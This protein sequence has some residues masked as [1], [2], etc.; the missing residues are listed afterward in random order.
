MKTLLKIIIVGVI[1]FS[2]IFAQGQSDVIEINNTSIQTPE[3]HDFGDVTEIEYVRYFIRNNRGSAVVVS[4]IKTPSGFFA[5]I[6]E[7]SIA[8]NKR[9][10]LYVGLDPSY[11]PE[12][13]EFEKEIII[14]TNLVT[15]IVVQVKG[16]I[17]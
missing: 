16:N 1:G 14:S 17:P 6:S 3:T 11:V 9:V 13:G 4:N 10:I 15:N 12:K 7:M 5:N 2:P 8:P